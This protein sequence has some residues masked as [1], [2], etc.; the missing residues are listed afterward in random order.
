MV[1]ESIDSAVQIAEEA[2]RKKEAEKASIAWARAAVLA[3]GSGVAAAEKKIAKKGAEEAA[4]KKK[5][6]EAAAKKKNEEE[7]AA[8]RKA[9]EDAV[10]KER[11]TDATPVPENEP[12][13][14][15]TD[16]ISP[17]QLLD[18][19]KIYIEKGSETMMIPSKWPAPKWFC[20]VIGT[21]NYHGSVK[22][23]V[24]DELSSMIGHHSGNVMTSYVFAKRLWAFMSWLPLNEVYFVPSEKFAVNLLGNERP[25]TVNWE[26][27]RSHL[28]EH[29]YFKSSHVGVFSGRKLRM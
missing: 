25:E 8:L 4:A 6:E 29:V 9:A 16:R 14:A 13:V 23:L 3:V 28:K 27:F 26:A 20:E 10:A 12:I 1:E 11:A 2:V 24:S 15:A 21:R 5:A 22:F 7:A 17:S 18:F 19:K